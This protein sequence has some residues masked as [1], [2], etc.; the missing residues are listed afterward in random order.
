MIKA[1]RELFFES[2]DC[3]KIRR[4]VKENCLIE[5]ELSEQCRYEESF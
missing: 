2:Y 4:E 5:T 3:D 1:C